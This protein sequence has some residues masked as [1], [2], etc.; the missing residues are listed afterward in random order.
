LVDRICGWH[1]TAA[2]HAILS[3]LPTDSRAQQAIALP[4]E[5]QILIAFMLGFIAAADSV[6][7]SVG[8]ARGA[9]RLKPLVASPA[10]TVR[11]MAEWSSARCKHGSMSQLTCIHIFIFY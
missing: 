8:Q 5:L 11:E 2:V 10:A 7:A 4:E 6:R 1:A 9:E 3:L